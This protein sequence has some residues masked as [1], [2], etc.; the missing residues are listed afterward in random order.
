MSKSTINELYQEI[1]QKASSEPLS[2]LLPSMLTLARRLHNQTMENWVR[3][4]MNGYLPENPAM[5]SD[6]VIPE[7]RTIA[8]QHSDEIGRPLIVNNPTLHFVNE[9]R[10]PMGVA[11]LENLAKEPEMLVVR[12][13]TFSKVLREKLGVEVTRFT[14]QPSAVVGV[15]SNIRSKLLDWLNEIQPDIEQMISNQENEDLDIKSKPSWHYTLIT[16]SVLTLIGSALWFYEER[17]FEPLIGIFAGIAGLIVYKS[18]SSKLLDLMVS[19]I[20]IILFIIGAVMVIR[21]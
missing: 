13:P 18:K 15:L 17:K 3:L 14:F 20:L 1:D 5:N 10:I 7:Y 16:V 12:D 2:Q 11:E 21:G 9:D 8:I 19:L 6:V 4:E